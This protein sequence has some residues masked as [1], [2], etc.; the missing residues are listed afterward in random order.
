MIRFSRDEHGVKRWEWS[1]TNSGG[2]EESQ[3]VRASGPSDSGERRSRER[4]PW[5]ETVIHAAPQ[6]LTEE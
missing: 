1:D 4:P 2:R 6:R 5:A 3:R